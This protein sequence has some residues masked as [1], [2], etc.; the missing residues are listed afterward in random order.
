MQE[1]LIALLAISVIIT[2]VFC[3]VKHRVPLNP[4]VAY[5][6][7][8]ISFVLGAVFPFI[9]SNVSPAGALAVY[10]VLIVF[11]AAA[12]SRL[13]SRASLKAAERPAEVAVL[14]AG[15][16]GYF[17]Q[18]PAS[19]F[20]EE[21]AAAQVCAAADGPPET[22]P[23][24][25]CR[26]SGRENEP[27]EQDQPAASPAGDTSAGIPAS[28]EAAPEESGLPDS[29]PRLAIPPA[30]E[31]PPAAE[32]QPEEGRPAG[33]NAGITDS[34]PFPDCESDSARELTDFAPERLPEDF[35]E[36]AAA[37]EEDAGPEEY[38]AESEILSAAAV[39]DMT[40]KATEEATTE[41][42]EEEAAIE[43]ATEATGK[44]AAVQD[45][46]AG[47]PA[48]AA[49]GRERPADINQLISEGFKAKTEGRHADVLNFFFKALGACRDGKIS[50]ALALEISSAFQ[51]LGQH[52]QAAMFLSSFARQEYV[53]RDP[54]LLQQ[55]RYRTF[56]L[57]TLADLLRY[58]KMP[59]A[60]NSKI[61]NLIKIKANMLTAERF[62]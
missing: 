20:P 49:D 38:F 24:D 54:S 15:H 23:E 37:G 58:A 6:A 3:L 48:S 7:V 60:P 11:F 57:E 40:E 26:E 41:A 28:G 9:I 12:L 52:V 62:K 29:G 30:E 61:P 27:P 46:A 1:Y 35:P 19:A 44:E 17:E 45:A 5:A 13:E 25:P 21:T 10:F 43:E 34:S 47:E 53:Q 4:K 33:G 16:A 51:E 55:I 32:A 31:S 18:P 8:G 22:S 59:N 36:E 50:S 39:E 14:Q 56:Y 2:S 42:A